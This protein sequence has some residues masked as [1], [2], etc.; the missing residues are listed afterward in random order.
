MRAEW[1]PLAPPGPFRYEDWGGVF[2]RM[3]GQQA[4][5][6]RHDQ[7]RAGRADL[8]HVAGIAGSELVHS[9]VLAW[10][11]KPS[12][13]HGLGTAFL[14]DLVRTT[15]GEEVEGAEAA[16][17]HRE[18][19]R[20]DKGRWRRTDVVVETGELTLVIE[21]KV[22]SDESK[23]QCEDLYRLWTRRTEGEGT[24]ARNVRFVLLSRHGRMPW[25]IGDDDEVRGAW[26]ALSYRWVAGWLS[27]HVERISSPVA[28]STAIQYLVAL[29]SVAGQPDE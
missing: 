11:L 22:Y 25:S 4:D 7:W 13:R 26:R 5:L 2:D 3:K 12:A 14:V 28:R 24:E 8:L 21:N 6:E 10:L 17:V 29:R 1:Q 15:W 9:A 20:R 23:G 18:V 27:D 19:E 16:A